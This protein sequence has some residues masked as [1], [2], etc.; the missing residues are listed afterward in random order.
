MNIITDNIRTVTDLREQ[1]MPLLE[2]LSRQEGPTVIFHRSRPKAVLLSIAA[3]QK[4]VDIFEDYF[5]EELAL[6]LEKQPKEKG[7]PLKQVMKEL[8]IKSPQMV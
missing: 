8:G 4:L 6:E 1:T 7:V 2:S 5:D 3:Y